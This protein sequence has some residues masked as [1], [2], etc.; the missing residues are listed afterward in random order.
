[1]IRLYR[2]IF[3]SAVDGSIEQFIKLLTHRKIVLRTRTCM[4][5]RLL[6][7]FCCRALQQIWG[8]QLRS[9]L[10]ALTNDDDENVKN[11][12]TYNFNYFI[13]T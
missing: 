7:R 1:M 2:Y 10:E 3:L 13:P 4:L 8:K 12:S 11:V 6:G 9:L 5:I